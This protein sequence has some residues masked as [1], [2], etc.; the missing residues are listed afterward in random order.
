MS[1][2]GE[3]YQPGLSYYHVPLALHDE[4]GGQL[5]VRSSWEDDAEWWASSAEN[6]SYSGRRV[7]RVDPKA[8]REPLDL[9]AAV[10]FFAR[11][12][13][14]FLVPGSTAKEA[15]AAVFMVGLDP[16]RSYHIEVD[17]EEMIEET[18]DPGGSFSFRQCRRRRQTGTGTRSVLMALVGGH[19]L[20]WPA[21]GRIN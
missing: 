15:D 5:F 13:K 2:C 17:G 9:D 7:T 19:R 11:E 3:S 8:A 10:V 1:S 20:S 18:A 21:F 14:Q 6:C 16:R 12:S 4:I